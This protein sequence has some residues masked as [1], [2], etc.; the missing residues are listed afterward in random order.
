ML[1]VGSGFIGLI[2][3]GVWLFALVDVITAQAAQV[4]NLQK[5]VWVLI[6]LFGLEI[7]AVLYL[8]YGRPKVAAGTR[9]RLVPSPGRGPAR[10]TGAPDDDIDFLR[11]LNRRP[12]DP[13]GPPPVG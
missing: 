5:V 8:I 11:S 10:R 9:S 12:T 7:G 3:L 4:R 13:D 1:F 2:A 6:V